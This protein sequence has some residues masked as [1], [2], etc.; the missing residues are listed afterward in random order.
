MVV[1]RENP[2]SKNMSSFGSY[3]HQGKTDDDNL[4]SVDLNID[5]LCAETGKEKTGPAL[6]VS[7]AIPEVATAE[8]T[9]A[10]TTV[11]SDDLAGT[12]DVVT[13]TSDDV[14]A[15]SNVMTKI[16]D[17]LEVTSNDVRGTSNVVTGTSDDLAG[18]SDDL[19]GTSDDV[20]EISREA[21]TTVGNNS[22]TETP[23]QSTASAGNIWFH[24]Y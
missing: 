24:F 10:T 8:V 5:D 20:V 2:T 15:I 1:V 11:T 14:A 12:S 22:E 4:Q 16:S 9:Q 7:S 6:T 3:P 13:E 17:V 18:T 21:A 19:A 23:T